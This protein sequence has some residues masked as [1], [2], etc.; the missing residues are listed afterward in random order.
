MRAKEWAASALDREQLDVAWSA[1]ATA[2]AARE[3][4]RQILLDLA[5]AALWNRARPAR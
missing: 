1:I 5:D 4:E 2:E 3:L